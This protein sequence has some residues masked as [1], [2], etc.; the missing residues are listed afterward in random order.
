ML[1]LV[2]QYFRHLARMSDNLC[3]IQFRQRVVGRLWHRLYKLKHFH[4]QCLPVLIGTPPSRFDQ[5]FGE[6]TPQYF[7]DLFT[8]N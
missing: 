1:T 4:P 5:V 8:I 3:S 7:V 2:D 6:R